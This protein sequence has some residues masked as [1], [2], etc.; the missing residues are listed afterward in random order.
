MATKLHQQ[1]LQS[2]YN[3]NSPAH[4]HER[5]MRCKKLSVRFWRTVRSIFCL[6]LRLRL[7]IEIEP[8][9]LRRL[10]LLY[11]FNRFVVCRSYTNLM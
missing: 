10:L 5:G 8:R 7:D 6:I 2:D 3:L 9:F 1:F 11:A 4:L